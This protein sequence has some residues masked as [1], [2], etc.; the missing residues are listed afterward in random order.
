[1]PTQRNWCGWR[2]AASSSSP[3]SLACAGQ[4][5]PDGRPRAGKFLNSSRGWT[6][7]IAPLHASLAGPAPGRCMP[8]RTCARFTLKD[9]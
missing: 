4:P 3:E 9:H 2:S 8:V 1:L 6:S 5:A 7:H